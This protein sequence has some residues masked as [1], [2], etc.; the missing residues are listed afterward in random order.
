MTQTPPPNRELYAEIAALVASL[1]KAFQMKEADVISGLDRNAFTLD[2]GRD[3]NGNR[4]VVAAHEGR[5]A[6]IYQGAI[7][8]EDPPP[9]GS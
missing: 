5:R 9:S 7:K 3:V 8:K 6:R 1:A 2:F 4:F